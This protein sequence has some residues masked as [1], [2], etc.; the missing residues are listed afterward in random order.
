MTSEA[1]PRERVTR[2]ILE[3]LAVSLGMVLFAWFAHRGLPWITLS[4]VGL[5]VTAATIVISLRSLPR[6]AEVLGLAGLPRH[7]VFFFVVGAVIGAGGGMLHRYSLGLSVW[8][9]GGVEVFAA[10]A[11]LI[12]ATEELVYRGWLQGRAQVLGGPAAIVIAAVAHAAYKT[13]LFAWPTTPMAIDYAGI[14][15]WTLLGGLVLGLLRAYSES[16]GPSMLAHAAFDFMVYGALVYAP[17][18]VWG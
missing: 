16:V 13:A 11:C 2:P 12:G 14:A 6:P 1:A 3:V 7:P 5:L 15:L 9:A 8:P 10:I 17:W 18:W 4:T